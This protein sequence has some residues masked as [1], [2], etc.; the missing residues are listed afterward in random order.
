MLSNLSPTSSRYSSQH[1]TFLYYTVSPFISAF[2]AQTAQL[3]SSKLSCC[4]KLSHTHAGLEWELN[5][6]FSS[7]SFFLCHGIKNWI[8]AEILVYYDEHIQHSFSMLL[9]PFPKPL[10]DNGIN[11]MD[12]ISSFSF[13]YLVVAHTREKRKLPHYTLLCTTATPSPKLLVFLLIS[14]TLDEF[15]SLGRPPTFTCLLLERSMV[16]G[17]WDEHAEE[18]NNV[19]MDENGATQRST[20][21]QRE[22][23]IHP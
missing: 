12:A 10:L 17:G 7:P 19:S 5:E 3:K 23:F 14:K 16:M 13:F 2:S 15:V 9:L 1:H 20:F 11:C 22:T 8:S 6:N 18:W 21:L 4:G